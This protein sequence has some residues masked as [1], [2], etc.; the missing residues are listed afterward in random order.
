MNV[1]NYEMVKF[2]QTMLVCVCV[3]SLTIKYMQSMSN[4]R[5]EGGQKSS[6]KNCINA[7]TFIMR[8]TD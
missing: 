4:V 5:T 2:R 1:D 6:A 7:I 8:F 3:G